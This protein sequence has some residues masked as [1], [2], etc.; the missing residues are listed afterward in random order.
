MTK[1]AKFT[2]EDLVDLCHCLVTGAISEESA[3]QEE[4]IEE[5]KPQD[6]YNWGR[7]ALLAEYSK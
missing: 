7:E 1:R 3:E 4:I 6:E 2:P 5:G